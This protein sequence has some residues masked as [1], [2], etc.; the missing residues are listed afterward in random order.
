MYG[1][2]SDFV[3]FVEVVQDFSGKIIKEKIFVTYKFI[4]N[5]AVVLKCNLTIL[6]RPIDELF[7]CGCPQKVG[8]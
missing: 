5:G 1:T 7:V 4:I 3:I 2:Q 6:K 8:G